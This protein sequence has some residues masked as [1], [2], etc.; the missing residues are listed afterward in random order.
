MT[1]LGGAAISVMLGG[2]LAVLGWWGF[3]NA[4]AV[5]TETL[6]E[7]DRR[8]RERVL[9]RGAVACQV[10]AVVFVATGVLGALH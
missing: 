3:R 9:R 5:V 1:T 2:M 4:A 6:P 7:P 8:R 10:L